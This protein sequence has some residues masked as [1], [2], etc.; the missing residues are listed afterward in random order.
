MLHHQL[1]G[2]YHQSHLLYQSK[3]FCWKLLKLIQHGSERVI[4]RKKSN[5]MLPG[6]QNPRIRQC[7][8]RGFG[9]SILNLPRY[10]Q[11]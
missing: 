8:G 7:K 5:Q 6:C 10:A 3:G 4:L 2:H 11:A 1:M 9:F